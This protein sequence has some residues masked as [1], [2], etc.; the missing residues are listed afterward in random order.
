[1]QVCVE[2]CPDEKYSGYAAAS[3]LPSSQDFSIKEKMRP[4]CEVIDQNHWDGSSPSR[5]IEEGIC[6]AWVLPS[7]PIIGRC[8]PTIVEVSSSSGEEDG[9]NNATVFAGS[10]T[11]EGKEVKAGTIKAAVYQ[12]GLFLEL[13]GFGE[14][15]F[16]DLS[17]SWWMIVVAL[18]AAAVL[19]FLWI[20]LMR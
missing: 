1:M 16:N 13:R 11:Q 2:K 17:N 7:Q 3:T 20:V 12:L 5:L 10:E 15:V 6:P 8:L 14:R 19:S 18:A 4:Y 9:G